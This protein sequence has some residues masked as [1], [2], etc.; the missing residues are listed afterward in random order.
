M[1]F[2]RLKLFSDWRIGQLL[3]HHLHEEVEV[4]HE[5]DWKLFDHRRLLREL[6]GQ[7]RANLV[8]PNVF[9][10]SAQLSL[11]LSLVTMAPARVQ[12]PHVVE[13]LMHSKS[14]TENVDYLHGLVIDARLCAIECQY[15]K[16]K[17]AKLC[18]DEVDHVDNDSL[19]LPGTVTQAWRVNDD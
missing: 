10:E 15:D 8:L 19:I 11:K 6:F 2:D 12:D 16:V 17:L 5:K 1:I 13:D 4:A 3:R 7:G 14:I 9:A 18:L